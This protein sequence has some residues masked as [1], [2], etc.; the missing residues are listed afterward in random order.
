MPAAPSH[1]RLDLPIRGMSCAACAARLEKAIAA[2]PGVHSAAVNF[3]THIATILHDP[4]AAPVD[5]LRATVRQAGFEALERADVAHGPL[6]PGEPRAEV[7]DDLFR[8]FL[9]GAVFT[10]PLVVIA[11]SHGRV[12]LFNVPWINWLQFALATP[13]V[14]VSGLP[15]MRSAVAAARGRA[16]NMDTLVSLGAGSAFIYSTLA[17]IQPGFF[18]GVTGSAHDS[19]MGNMFMVPVYFEAAAVIVVLVLLGK[20]I[21]ARATSRTDAAVR[22]LLALEP[23]TARVVRA[24]VE[25]DIPVADVTPGDT[26][27]LRPGEQVPVDASV[28]SGES[29]VDESMLTGESL[30]VDKAAGDRVLAGTLNTTGSLR[31]AAEAV[32]ADTTLR[33]IARLVREA[34]GSKA[35]I[36]R[37]ADRVSGVFVPI[38]LVLATLTF[39]AWWLLAP[40]GSRLSIALL[41]SVSVLIIACPC[42]LGL[43]T[44]TAIIAATGRAARRG[45]LIKSAPALEAAARITTV[46]L[47]KTGTLTS[48]RPT[49]TDILP[50][51]GFTEAE[52]LR[53]AASAQ[54]PSEHPIAGAVVRAAAD[55]DVVL[56]EP[57]AF[58]AHPGAG[59][60]AVVEGCSVLI[61][62]G[63][64]LAGRGIHVSLTDRAAA[65]A[66]SG[67]TPLFVAVDGAPAGVL[68]VVDSVKPS[69]AAAVAA[70]RESGLNVVMLT[71]DQRP[72]ADAVA[73]A[74]G[75]ERVFAEVYPSEKAD[76]VARLQHSTP[77]HRVAMV[78]DGVNDAPALARADVGV[79]IATGAGAALH[80]ADITLLRDDLAGLPEA[81]ALAR[82][83]LRTIRQNLGWAFAYNAL[84][85][86]LAAG[87]L[88][89]VT[90]WL[91]SPML[92]SAA[93]ALSSISVVLNS[94][95]LARPISGR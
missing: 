56:S 11:M 74:V 73:R 65:L 69:A 76:L 55:R 85:I 78:G 5:A 71:G 14:L 34:Q 30:P 26:L 7:A 17:T 37:V 21:E 53:L 45:I 95:R 28:V 48:G 63:T 72:V 41:T 52:L 91:L 83:T 19:S 84:C 67:R 66:A 64:L 49:L 35:P 90:G 2:R 24:G 22:S 86:P 6:E 8:R 23:R 9:F 16:A 32:G 61:G 81:L 57:I 40:P 4:A 36:A 13:V 80:A 25:A 51:P 94:L 44:P 10:L 33:Q 59:V 3:A 29:S 89:P 20:Y 50:A 18:A 46:V 88:Y 38:V 92:A 43:A 82:Q 70:L 87:V 60:E 15:F 68:A 12:A 77:A 1:A 58:R 75:I 31:L 27:I 39:A 47:D 79:A 62:R 93:M 54:R 42:A